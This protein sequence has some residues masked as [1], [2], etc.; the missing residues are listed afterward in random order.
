MRKPRFTEAEYVVWFTQNVL[1]LNPTPL[2]ARLCLHPLCYLP[3]WKNHYG[4]IQ[5]G[6]NI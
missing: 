4:K 3:E 6:R 1:D 5:E 2:T